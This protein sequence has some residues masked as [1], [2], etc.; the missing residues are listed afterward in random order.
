MD[1]QQKLQATM[2]EALK[3]IKEAY[4]QTEVTTT[5]VVGPARDK[6]NMA[7][8]LVDKAIDLAEGKK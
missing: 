1:E 7:S 4:K 8:R 2:L 6:L 5:V 3:A